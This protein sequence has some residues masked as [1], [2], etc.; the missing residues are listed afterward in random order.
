M[1]TQKSSYFIYYYFPYFAFEFTEAKENLFFSQE[2][3][4]TIALYSIVKAI[5]FTSALLL[6]AEFKTR[7][8]F[9]D[10]GSIEVLAGGQ[11]SLCI[12]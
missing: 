7:D 12:S 5:T 4:F 11:I 10:K 1:V 8:T 2:K 6:G 9:L 3:Y